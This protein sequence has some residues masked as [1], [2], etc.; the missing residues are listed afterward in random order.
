MGSANADDFPGTERF[1]IERRLGAGGF[2]VVYRAYDRKRASV[3][4]L[5]ALRRAE[6]DALYRFK[7]EFRALADLAHRN[8]VTLYEL[9]ADGDQWFFTMELVEGSNF[10]DHVRG[11]RSRVDLGSDE[12]TN[13]PAPTP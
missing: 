10:L 1:S 2:G 9:L 3:V 6:S 5:K 8:L 7:Q 13:S 11:E 4:A 12:A